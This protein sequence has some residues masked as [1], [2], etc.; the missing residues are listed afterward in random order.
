ML[1]IHIFRYP[2]N[3]LSQFD[4]QLLCLAGDGI[5]LRLTESA[6]GIQFDH[7]IAGIGRSHNR[8]QHS[9]EVIFMQAMTDGEAVT[10]AQL[11]IP[12]IILQS[13]KAAGVVLLHQLL[14]HR[15]GKFPLCLEGEY[16]IDAADLGVAFQIDFH[17]EQLAVL[18]DAQFKGLDALLVGIILV[19]PA[20]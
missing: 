4:D 16:R 18:P 6:N 15:I 3:L 11:A 2:Y 1:A 9:L 8:H 20:L 13:A 10:V 12:L 19:L 5:A 7:I 14:T 17:M